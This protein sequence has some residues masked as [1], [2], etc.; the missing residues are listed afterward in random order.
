MI[1]SGADPDD[2]ENDDKSVL[3]TVSSMD[4]LKWSDGYW[5]NEPMQTQ[6]TRTVSPSD[7]CVGE[8]ARFSGKAALAKRR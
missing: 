6:R 7:V 1:E 8:G 5:T 3:M 4:P 2:K